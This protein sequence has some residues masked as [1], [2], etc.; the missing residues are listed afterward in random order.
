LVREACVV[1]PGVLP[2]DPDV[3]HSIHNP[4]EAPLVALH[5]Y[6]GDLLS[7]PRSNWDPESH[8]EIPFDWEKISSEADG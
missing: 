3:I 1:G 8:E 7:T 6:G 2:N 5:A 4:L